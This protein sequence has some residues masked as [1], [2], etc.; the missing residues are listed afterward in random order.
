MRV[1]KFSRRVVSTI[2]EL[3]SACRLFS[4][5]NDW[6]FRGQG[7][8]QWRLVSSLD[9][10]IQSDRNVNLLSD[11]K[12]KKLDVAHFLERYLGMDI[13]TNEIEILE[14]N[15]LEFNTEGEGNLDSAARIQHA[16]MPTR[17]LDFTESIETALYFALAGVREEFG[18]MAIWCVRISSLMEKLKTAFF[19]L[20]EACGQDKKRFGK[21]LLSKIYKAEPETSI[22]DFVIPVWADHNNERIEAQ[23]GLFLYPFRLGN[24]HYDLMRMVSCAEVQTNVWPVDVLNADILKKNIVKIEIDT[25]LRDE[26]EGFLEQR[27]VSRETL[28]VPMSNSPSDVHYEVRYNWKE[29]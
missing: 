15:R 29:C 3:W 21:K 4:G 16:E 24:F 1:S 10:E 11:Y 17:L 26:I 23:K 22:S 2:D 20:W 12:A 27:G 18:R 8:A 13:D 19:C 7:D 5:D 6:A 25:K 9:R 14:R 28:M